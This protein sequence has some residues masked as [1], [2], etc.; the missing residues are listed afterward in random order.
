[1]T[2]RPAN[3]VSLGVEALRRLTAED[4]PA[5][6]ITRARLLTSGRGRGRRRFLAFG[7]GFAVLVVVSGTLAATMFVRRAPDPL[8]PSPP[9]A[10]PSAARAVVVRRPPVE[11]PVE[12][13]ESP[14]AP[15]ANGELVSYGAAHAAHFVRKEFRAGAAPLDSVSRA[16]P[17]RALRSRSDLQPRAHAGAPRPQQAGGRG[18]RSRIAAGRFGDYRRQEAEALLGALAA[19]AGAPSP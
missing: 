4:G 15:E 3:R 8:P 7:F 9:A 17:T 2:R 13:P 16:L 14:A 12:T 10:A 5:A 1:M 19:G 6:S 11:T 18:A